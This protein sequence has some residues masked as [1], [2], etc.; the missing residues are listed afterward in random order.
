MLGEDTYAGIGFEQFINILKAQ[1]GTLSTGFEKVKLPN[2]VK[3][4]HMDKLESLLRDLKDDVTASKTIKNWR[5]RL[6]SI[7]DGNC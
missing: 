1:Y 3:V 5:K 4:T 7:R 6:Y 2:D